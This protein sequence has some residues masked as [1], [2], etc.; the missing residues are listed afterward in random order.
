MS[1]IKLGDLGVLDAVE[2]VLEQQRDELA[3]KYAADDAPRA[4]VLN[5]VITQLKLNIMEQLRSRCE[6]PG[7]SYS[8]MPCL[9]RVCEILFVRRP[10]HPQDWRSN[11]VCKQLCKANTLLLQRLRLSLWILNSLTKSWRR[12]IR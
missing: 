11:V 4:A 1:S 12:K 6:A 10:S 2:Q 9:Q 8:Y 5:S 7:E 3:K